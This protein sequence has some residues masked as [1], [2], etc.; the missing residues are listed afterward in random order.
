M[1]KLFSMAAAALL[2]TT[3]SLSFSACS[4]KDDNLPD[5]PT[6]AAEAKA[7][8][9][10]NQWMVAESEL[11]DSRPLGNKARR[12]G[13]TYFDVTSDGQV[14]W[15]AMDDTDAEPGAGSWRG[16]LLID[17]LEI[18]VDKNNPTQGYLEFYLFGGER[19]LKFAFYG[20]TKNGAYMPE[21][22]NIVRNPKPVK[23][24][25]MRRIE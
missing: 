6:T 23:Y 1:K 7:M 21:F 19:L 4:D 15:V 11:L 16:Q 10:G 2:V 8:I 3:L 17:R 22:G 5:V 24:E 14:Y 9:L 12:L 18:V 25:K 13:P 20:L